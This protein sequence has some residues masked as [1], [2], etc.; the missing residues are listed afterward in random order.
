MPGWENPQGVGPAGIATA[1]SFSGSQPHSLS[2]V[3]EVSDS[4]EFPPLGPHV[5][6]L[7]VW[8]KVPQSFWTPE[9]MPGSRETS[10]IPPLGLLTIAALC[11][12]NWTIRF[13]DERVEE[14]LDEHIRGADLVMVSGMQVQK[15]AIRKILLR[16]RSHGKRTIIGGPYASSEPESL[17]PFANHV[18]IGEP[19]AV[20][21]HIAAELENG[22]A[23]RVYT[24]TDKPDVSGSP[25]PRFDLLSLDRYATMAIQF[26]RG[27]PFQC[28]FCDIITIYGRTPRTKQP[29]QVLAELE[30]LFQLG[31]RKPVFIV[32][33]NFIGN[34]KRALELAEKLEEWS[35]SHDYPFLFVTEAS[36][37]LAQRPALV[38]AMVKANFYGVFVGVECPSEESLKE[39]KKFQN[40]RADPIESI[41][42]LQ[43]KGLWVTAGFIIGFDCD[44]EDIFERQREFVERSAIAW[45]MLGF[46]QAP[47]TTPLYRRMQKEGRLLSDDFISNFHPPNF[48]TLIPLPVLLRGFVQTLRA[49][50]RPS[51][52]YDRCLRSLSYWK[53]KGQKAPALPLLPAL[54][55]TLALLWWQGIRSDY[56]REWWKF[57]YEARQWFRDPLKRWWAFALLASGHHFINYARDVASQLEGEQR[58]LAAES[59]EPISC[60]VASLVKTASS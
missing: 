30:T 21:A 50:Y 31:W 14:L 24:I 41:R 56:R 34:H 1:P 4:Q 46:L 47:P 13:I 3:A 26:S 5:K 18:V 48:R 35:A 25:V 8:P 28:E 52:Y 40:L 29:R 57:L 44:R 55:M 17:L 11:P 6:A 7:L 32:D 23:Q 51:T 2:P 33:D 42:F 49:L 16:A 53:P 22:T 43:E 15:E 10:Q 38:D 37:D 27:C 36:I 60:S 45:A 12:K 20:F 39:T 9:Q 59:S 58:R 54:R 19:D